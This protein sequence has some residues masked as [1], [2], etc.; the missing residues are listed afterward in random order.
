[1]N[2]NE[3]QIKALETAIYPKYGTNFSYPLISLF[4]E[5]GELANKIKK[6]IRDDKSVI[7]DEKRDEIKDELGDILWYLVVLAYEFGFT[8][9]EVAQNNLLKLK[10]RQSRNVVKGSGD[11]R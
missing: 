7:T 5:C 9:D 10:D 11:K 4:G 3:Y 6:I 1:M 2:L 8:F